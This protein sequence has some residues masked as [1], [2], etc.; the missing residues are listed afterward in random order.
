MDLH[1]HITATYE[2]AIAMYTA[3]GVM[4]NPVYAVKLFRQAAHLGHPGAA[5]MLGECLLDGVGTKRDRA[6][7]LEWLV[8]AAELG[9]QVARQRVLAVL[10]EE[11]H[12]DLDDDSN[13]AKLKR[14]ETPKWANEE[15]EEAAIKLER[16]HTIGISNPK[17]SE[18]RKSK[19]KESREG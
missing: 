17:V 2:L 1:R 5:Y 10:Q 9:H 13:L 4:E 16:R 12:F 18:R 11:H 7:A 3:E 14:K 8:T 6:A 15:E 19:V